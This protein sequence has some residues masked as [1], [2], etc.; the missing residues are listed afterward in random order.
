MLQCG[1]VN[2]LVRSS[3]TLPPTGPN[4]DD[5]EVHNVK[6]DRPARMNEEMEQTGS[7]TK[8]LEKGGGNGRERWTSRRRIIDWFARASDRISSS[9]KRLRRCQ[10]SGCTFTVLVSWGKRAWSSNSNGP[11]SASR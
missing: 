7:M 11:E 4:N 2:S 1:T 10:G 3:T 5:S 8:T 6:A 9:T